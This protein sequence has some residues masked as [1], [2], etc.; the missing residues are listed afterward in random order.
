MNWKTTLILGLVVLAGGLGWWWFEATKSGTRPETPAGPTQALLEQL[1]PDRLLRIEIL[2]GKDTVVLEREPGKAWT[3]P[4][5]W[6]V[7]DAE[8]Q[9]FVTALA[10]LRTRFAAI[11]LGDASKFGITADSLRLK[12]TLQ[13]GNEKRT[14]LFTLGEE[15]GTGVN[16]FT[17]ATYLRLDENN[18]VVRLGPGL[19]A[20]LD[21]PREHFQK[22]RLFAVRRVLKEKDKKSGPRVEQLDAGQVTVETADSV[23][24]LK[25]AGEEWQLT[26]PFKDRADPDQL[27]KLLQAFPDLWA[28][29]F[30]D[31]RPYHAATYAAVAGQLSQRENL[32]GT[33]AGLTPGTLLAPFGLDKPQ[34]TLTVANGPTLLVGA[35]A[36]RTGKPKDKFDFKSADEE[37]RFAKLKKNDQIF[38][39]RSEKLRDIAVAPESLRDPQLARFKVEDVQR[40]TIQQDKV[41]LVFLRKKEKEGGKD[42]DKEVKDQWRMLRPQDQ[43]VESQLV[44]EM[45]DKL[46]GRTAD[47]F[48]HPDAEA[49]KEKKPKKLDE[50]TDLLKDFLDK[51]KKEKKDLKG[52]KEKKEKKEKKDPKDFGL[53]KPLVV[54]VEVEEKKKEEPKKEPV[55]KTFT[56]RLGTADA[57]KGK[58]YV[59]VDSWPRINVLD[60]SL[61]KLVKRE[62]VA[63]R[64]RKLLDFAARDLSEI[65]IDNLPRKETVRLKQEKD[66]WRMLQ[67]VATDVDIIR[68]QAL[69]AELGRLEAVEFLTA[70]PKKDDLAKEYGLEKPALSVHLTIAPEKKGKTLRIGRQR[71]DKKEY[72]ARLDEGPIFTLAQNT[73]ETLDKDSLAYRDLRLWDVAAGDILEMHIERL[74]K[75]KEHYALQ[76]DGKDWKIAGRFKAPAIAAQV[77]DITNEL[78][79]ANRDKFIVHQADKLD[80]YGLDPPALRLTLRTGKK[81]AKEKD[82][83]D[84]KKYVLEIGATPDKEAKARYAR[85]EGDKAIFTLSDK[86]A[87]ALDRTDLDF[88]DRQL[89][90]LEAKA[91]TQIRTSGLDKNKKPVSFTLKLDKEKWQVLDSPA[92]PF[93]PDEVALRETLGAWAP[94]RA[95]RF[96]D[97]Q[98]KDWGIFGLENPAVTVTVLAGGKEHRLA[99]GLEVK[100][101]PGQYYARVD[102]Q[103]GVAILDELDVRELKR[104]HLDFVDRLVLKEKGFDQVTI[105]HRK[106]GKEEVELEKKDDDWKL[107]KPVLKDADALIMERLLTRTFPLRARRIAAYPATPAELKEFG[108]D[109]P[110]ALVTFKMGGDSPAQFVVKIGKPVLEPGPKSALE[111]YAQVDGTTTAFVLAGDLAQLLTAS[112]LNF[113][114]HNL[115]SF[116]AADKLVF[117]RGDPKAQ[118]YRKAVFVKDGLWKMTEPVKAD[119]EDADLEEFLKGLYRLRA[120]E[121]VSE[122][123]A[124]RKLYGLEPPQLRFRFTKGEEEVLHLVVGKAKEDGRYYAQLVSKD[125][126]DLIFLLS[127]KLSGKD[128]AARGHVLTEYR[129]RKTWSLPVDAA[130]IDRV[131]YAGKTSFVLQKIGPIWHALNQDKFKVS[132]KT[133]TDTLD[134][135][136]DLQAARYVVD[137]NANLQLY[138]LAP[139]PVLSIQMT[140]GKHERILHIG[141]QE[142]ESQRYYATVPGA[143][144]SAVF[145]IS[146]ADAR[147]IVRALQAF[148]E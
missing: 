87:R 73:F 134:A 57:D 122:N 140:V 27:Q 147:R 55:K 1:K 88:L 104:S 66:G 68:V 84:K 53:D 128:P 110:E 43:V 112:A 16:R 7:R 142:G 105:V 26:R 42:K 49:R 85:L 65:A 103:D 58:L 93:T 101:H 77:N 18:E 125:S 23:F 137:H 47:E 52:E 146:E 123:P 60:D 37:F 61:W 20:A 6:P 126:K 10:G 109:P 133:V 54:V 106:M 80:K 59:Q 120:D 81:D 45:L 83:K 99:F 44:T 9:R 89:L 5:G 75:T 144:G 15:T 143:E 131:S 69:A 64:P 32:L 108:L 41:E 141:R 70:A 74:G 50:D 51:K 124:D 13:D 56:F 39:I 114:D 135:L 48:F 17:R 11:P 78:A 29:K 8:V 136:A 97:Y 91:I 4:G 67:P 121:I 28:E 71:P 40:L 102:K 36:P 100:D 117:E 138:G 107:L 129:S 3:L 92:K 34:Y 86:I 127:A 116:S 118:G 95:L 22:P 38:E 79:F 132:D 25:R 113:R 90:P 130:Q 21:R 98:P 139:K 119:A 33:A 46:A 76:R 115:V 145:I 19:L 12:V 63:Y 62:A 24:T 111:R 2:R 82:A 96:A 35:A 14:H 148:K 31:P 72:Y 94:L 30:I